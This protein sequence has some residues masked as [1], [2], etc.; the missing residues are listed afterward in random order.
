VTIPTN[1]PA[2]AG[3]EDTLDIGASD[4]SDQVTTGD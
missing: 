1:V 4:R 3:R 2:R